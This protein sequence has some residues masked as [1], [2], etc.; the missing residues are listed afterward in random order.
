MQLT[1]P[2][3]VLLAL[4]I[5]TAAYRLLTDEWPFSVEVE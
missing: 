4:G 2:E 1:I 3:R 5:L